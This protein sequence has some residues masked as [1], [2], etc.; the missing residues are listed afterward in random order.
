MTPLTAMTTAKKRDEAPRY[1][2]RCARSAAAAWLAHRSRPGGTR[3]RGDARPAAVSAS[4]KVSSRLLARSG[5]AARCTKT[6][7]RARRRR[8]D[9]D[10]SAR[11]WGRPTSAIL[12][13]APGRPSNGQPKRPLGRGDLFSDLQGVAVAD[14]AVGQP[15]E[16]RVAVGQ[17]VELDRRACPAPTSMTPATD[18]QHGRHRAGCAA[19]RAASTAGCRRRA[20]LLLAL[21]CRRRSARAAGR[22][23]PSPRRRRRC[24]GRR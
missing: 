1:A 18:G 3:R 10:V 5:S 4:V 6:P 23:C 21:A 12:K 11:P 16:Q 24:T 15:H 17:H 22:P 19:G 9:R 13:A 7:E 8:V 2:S 20:R 14:A